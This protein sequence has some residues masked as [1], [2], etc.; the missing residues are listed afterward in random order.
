[1]FY[2]GGHNSLLKN[3]D[4]FLDWED[5]FPL[6]PWLFSAHLIPIYTLI[7]DTGR[8]ASM[9]LA[10]SSYSKPKLAQLGQQSSDALRKYHFADHKTNI[11]N[12]YQK[13]KKLMGELTPNAAEVAELDKSVQF[14][15]VPGSW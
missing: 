5:S 15:L 14:Y 2:R 12:L 10:L 13:W 6:I 4:Q 9:K 1:M 7:N 8:K 3:D 11:K